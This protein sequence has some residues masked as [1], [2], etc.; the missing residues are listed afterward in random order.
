MQAAFLQ[1]AAHT[2]VQQRARLRRDAAPA[3]VVHVAA[4]LA[5]EL[6]ML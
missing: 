3:L 4:R 1:G 6:P 5:A 2:Q